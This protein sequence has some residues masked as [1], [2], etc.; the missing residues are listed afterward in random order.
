MKANAL[1]PTAIHLRRVLQKPTLQFFLQLKPACTAPYASCRTGSWQSVTTTFEM[2][3]VPSSSLILSPFS[4]F[5]P[6]VRIINSQSIFVRV[7]YRVPAHHSVGDLQAGNSCTLYFK[8]AFTP[9]MHICV[10]S[11]LWRLSRAQ[12]ES[13]L[14]EKLRKVLES[15][16][17]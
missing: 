14:L 9:M 7:V 2:V 11:S 12:T 16:S 5:R 17:R 4:I 15:A 1:L 8:L 10:S 6:G 13:V 3:N